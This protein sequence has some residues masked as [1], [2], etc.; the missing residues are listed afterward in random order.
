[1]NNTLIKMKIIDYRI[2]D[3]YN[4]NTPVIVFIYNNNFC[5]KI[6]QLFEEIEAYI[7]I[8]EDII[9]KGIIL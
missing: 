9:D 3:V 6:I 5:D 8:H 1:M 4:F 2:F 7:L